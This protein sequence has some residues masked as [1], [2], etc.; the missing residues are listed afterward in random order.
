MRN[1]YQKYNKHSLCN[2]AL[3][4][5]SSYLL[6]SSMAR[7]ISEKRLLNKSYIAF[8]TNH[9][10]NN[11]AEYNLP[12]STTRNTRTNDNKRLYNELTL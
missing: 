7:A 4:F 12:M 9:E 5:S 1:M 3:L 2:M 11:N 6:H 10:I 8:A